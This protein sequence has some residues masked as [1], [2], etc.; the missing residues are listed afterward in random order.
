MRYIHTLQNV[1]QLGKVANPARGQLNKGKLVFPRPHSRLRIWSRMKGSFSC[2][3]PRKP[4]HSVLNRMLTQGIT[5]I[6][7]R[8]APCA[9][10]SVPRLSGNI[11][12]YRW[13]SLP[14]VRRHRAPVVLKV[15]PVT[16]T[17]F[18]QVT[19]D[20]LMCASLFPHRPSDY[21]CMWYVCMAIT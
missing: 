16:D 14:S 9:I 2:P 10:G 8:P 6:N 11:I 17:A 15:V 5:P 19:V 12:A 7:L 13:C 21:V 3:V 4:A 20:Q 1:D 18:L